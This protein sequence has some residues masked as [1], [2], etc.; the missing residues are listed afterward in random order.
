MGSY[1]RKV[2]TQN[3]GVNEA[4]VNQGNSDAVTEGF[5]EVGPEQGELG[6]QDVGGVS[7]EG[8]V[9]GGYQVTCNQ[10]QLA[11][12]YRPLELRRDVERS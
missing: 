1:A 11:C 3:S 7:H 2:G 5:D 10:S 12:W 9:C 4:Y 8:E 6:G